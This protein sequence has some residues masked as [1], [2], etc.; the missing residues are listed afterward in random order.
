MRQ[1]WRESKQKKKEPSMRVI[2]VT[3]RAVFKRLKDT[4]FRFD[5]PVNVEIYQQ[6]DKWMARSPDTL[7]DFPFTACQSPESMKKECAARFEK[8]LSDKWWIFG[9]EPA[10]KGGSKGMGDNPVR[11]LQPDEIQIKD[12]KVYFL[13]TDDYTHI[14]DP[15]NPAPRPSP[16][17]NPAA[18]GQWPK[19]KNFISL[20]AN[21]PPSCRQCAEVYKSHAGVAQ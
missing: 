12:G 14:M 16:A 10:P 5:G 21:I 6:K 3:Y 11:E 9:K 13:E 1:K 17:S 8:Q 4:L 7:V 18:C 2:H 15:K 20:K 19:M